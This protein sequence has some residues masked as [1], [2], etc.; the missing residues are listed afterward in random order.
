MSESPSENANIEDDEDIV[1]FEVDEPDNGLRL[2]RYLADYC[3]DLSRTRI[4][5]LIEE[6]AVTVNQAMVKSASS[7]IQ[8]GDIITLFM[9][10]P[11][12]HHP[13]PENIPLDIV[14]EDEDLLVINKASGMV[15]HP[16]PGHHSGT[17]VNALLYHCGES[18]SGIGGVRRPG[19]VH[20]LDKETTGL[21]LVAKNDKA[22]QYL[23]AQLADRSLSRHYY[24]LVWGALR[25]VRGRVETSIGR[26]RN[27]RQ[28]MAPNVKN[29]RHAITHYKRLNVF[30]QAA[31]AVEC[32]LETG[33]THQIR[34]HMQHDGYPL[35]GDPVYRI[36]KTKAQSLLRKSGIEDDVAQVILDF[37]RQ[38][39]HARQLEFI[40]PNEKLMSFTADLPADIQGL[41][42]ILKNYE[43]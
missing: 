36:Q 18:L 11:V 15:V 32:Q 4:K 27:N 3:E 34:V 33:R 22:H 24:A 38:A 19:I 37:P 10:P 13:E 16:A 21:M 17:L 39:L 28:M 12:D 6:G 14:Y 30:G 2:D 23:S 7:K 1:V 20:R 25:F 9:P 43:K 26:H 31:S 41:L 8:Q 35:V 5:K 42:A 29:G 40:H